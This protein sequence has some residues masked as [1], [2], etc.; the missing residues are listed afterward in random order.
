M[1]DMRC[2]GKRTREPRLT[3]LLCPTVRS[4]E[5]YNALEKT[6][7]QHDRQEITHTKKSQREWATS[8]LSSQRPVFVA[9]S[10]T[11]PV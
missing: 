6:Y 8:L 3:G 1:Q 7:E 2:S 9:A 11:F 10:A 5:G 4:T